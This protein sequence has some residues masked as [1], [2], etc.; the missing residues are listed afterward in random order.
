ML[1]VPDIRMIFIAM[2]S[3][4]AVITNPT[5]IV[6]THQTASAPF[7]LSLS[8]HERLAKHP[9]ASS[10]FVASSA[11]RVNGVRGMQA[12]ICQFNFG[13]FSNSFL[14]LGPAISPKSLA[15]TSS[16]VLSSSQ[17]GPS[18]LLGFSLR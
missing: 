5:L 11:E 18:S 8:K 16:R 10:G 4:A 9:S 6:R 13:V 14:S 7:V 17:K 15:N 12:R 1:R 2:Q 3:Q